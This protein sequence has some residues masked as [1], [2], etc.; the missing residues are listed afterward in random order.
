MRMRYV[1]SLR[2]VKRILETA[3]KELRSLAGVVI[4]IGFP[5][6][7]ERKFMD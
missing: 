7:H 1:A 4:G 6:D 2:V 5:L 3:K